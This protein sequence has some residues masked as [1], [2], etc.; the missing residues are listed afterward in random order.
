MK[1]TDIFIK[2]PNWNMQRAALIV[3]YFPVSSRISGVTSF[4]M[5]LAKHRLFCGTKTPEHPAEKI[6]YSIERPQ[7][8]RRIGEKP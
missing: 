1:Y 7:L 3:K 2:M 8:R 6:P 4:A 5:L